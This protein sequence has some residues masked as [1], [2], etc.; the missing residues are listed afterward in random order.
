MSLNF[1]KA[2]MRKASMVLLAAAVAGGI[3]SFAT[4]TSSYVEI[5]IASFLTAMLLFVVICLDFDTEEVRI[6]A[7]KY[8]A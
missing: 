8:A 7:S 4:G 1:D 2:S 3:A 6:Q 5:Q